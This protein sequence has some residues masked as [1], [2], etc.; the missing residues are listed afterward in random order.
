MDT[1]LVPEIMQPLSISVISY[2]TSN[3]TVCFL[4]NFVSKVLH[5]LA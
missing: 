3:I 4:V 1:L 5:T 2:K